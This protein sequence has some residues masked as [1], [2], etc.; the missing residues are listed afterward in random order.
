VSYRLRNVT[1]SAALG[2]LASAALVVLIVV[3]ATTT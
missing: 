2:L 1:V 3:F